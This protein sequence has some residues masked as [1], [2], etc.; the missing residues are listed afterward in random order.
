MYSF[1]SFMKETIPVSFISACFMKVTIL[2]ITGAQSVQPL[3]AGWTTEES[4][5]KSR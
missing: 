2:Y 3:A 4:G 1:P 5:F